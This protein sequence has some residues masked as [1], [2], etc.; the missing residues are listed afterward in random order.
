MHFFNA[1]VLCAECCDHLDCRR[2]PFT[3]VFVAIQPAGMAAYLYTSEADAWSEPTSAPHSDLLFWREHGAH[4]GNSL[5][6]VFKAI[7]GHKIILEYDLGTREMTVIHPP[8]ISNPLIVLMT[9]EGGGLGCLT[10]NRSRLHLWLWEADPNEDMGWA[11]S[12]VIDHKTLVPV[13][14][15]VRSFG[16]VDFADGGGMVYLDTDNGFYVADLKSMHF[17]K[18][19]G[20]NGMDEIIPYISFYTPAFSVAS[21]GEDPRVDA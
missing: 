18:A 4:V 13:G 14:A 12:R 5:Y 7:T 2:E 17:R 11:Q 6:F 21:T 10:I 20:V 19:E 9:A 16:A 15:L 1:A 8:P 3:V